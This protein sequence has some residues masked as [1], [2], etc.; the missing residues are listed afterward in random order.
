MASR[1]A[2]F[3]NLQAV[4]VPESVPVTIASS[5]ASF[6]NTL[7][8]PGSDRQFVVSAVVSY[9][10]NLPVSASATPE[11]PDSSLPLP[12]NAPVQANPFPISASQNK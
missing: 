4:P 1:P 10:R 2:S 12:L 5:T 11:S 8:V 7:E 9:R 3:A 6:F